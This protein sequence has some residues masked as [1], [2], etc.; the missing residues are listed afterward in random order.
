MNMDDFGPGEYPF[1]TVLSKDITS[2]S[3]ANNLKEYGY[4]THGIHNN[5]ATF[6]SR[7]IVYPNLGIDTFTSLEYMTDVEVNALGWA[8]DGVLTKYV[9]EALDSTE[10]SDFVFTVSVQGH[11]AYPE[12]DELENPSLLV[13]TEGFNG[14][15]NYNAYSY[16]L[17]QLHEMDQFVAELIESL[18]NRDEETVLVLYGDHLP[19][20]DITQ[21]D[22]STGTLYDTEYVIWTNFDIGERQVKDME[23][24]ELGSY[25]MD[26]LGYDAGLITK[27]HQNKNTMSEEDY[28]D[29][30]QTLEYDMLYGDKNC[31]NGIS[32]YVSNEV[33]YGYDEIKITSVVMIADTKNEGSY[34]LL[35]NGENFTEYSQIYLEDDTKLD[36]IYVNENTLF[37]PEIQL[38]VGDR[39][40]IH[41]ES[42]TT[43]LGISED[44]YLTDKDM[45]NEFKYGNLVED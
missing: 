41:Q 37:V 19:G 26:L 31:W 34:Y 2:E 14:N 11:G 21:E 25:V 28:L 20:F 7:R 16:Y 32:P 43:T 39:L 29:A 8:K 33:K 44:Y 13:S 30:L 24:Y 18:E 6:Y 45:N 40:S 3:I 12:D 9:N 15:V 5:V 42:G 23:A 22:L 36:S 38:S 4:S 35:V 27:L 1:K 17:E 10:G